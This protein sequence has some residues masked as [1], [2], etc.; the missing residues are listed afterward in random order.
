M[1]IELN[2]KM[3]SNLFV[4]ILFFFLTTPLVF[5]SVCFYLGTHEDAV[6][7]FNNH[8]LSI[9][10]GRLFLACIVLSIIILLCLVIELLWNVCKKNKKHLVY[11]FRKSVFMYFIGICYALVLLLY[12]FFTYGYIV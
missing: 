3:K 8:A 11:Y 10:F 7:R 9:I 6:E 1:G 5:L 12:E 2:S 4:N